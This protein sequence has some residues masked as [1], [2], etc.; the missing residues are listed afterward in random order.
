MPVIAGII[1]GGLLNIVG[2]LVGRVFLA[3]GLGVVSYIGF[4]SILDQITSMGRNSLIGLPPEL[5]QILG[6]LRIGEVFSMY[7]SAVS[8]KMIYQY[9][10]SNGTIKRMGY[11]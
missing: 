8:I 7:S 2:T 9:G 11:R 5:K 6:L 10:L 4:G 3:I 1:W